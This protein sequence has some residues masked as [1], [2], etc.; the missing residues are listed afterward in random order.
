ML[1]L[2][3]YAVLVA[4]KLPQLTDTVC[5]PNKLAIFQTNSI[6]SI[7]LPLEL[8]WQSHIS[9]HSHVYM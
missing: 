3:K 6:F 9:Q 5:L 8:K 2:T 1:N 7:F 4:V